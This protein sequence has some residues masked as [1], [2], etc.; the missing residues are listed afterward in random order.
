[1]STKRDNYIENR[2]SEGGSVG[3]KQSLRKAASQEFD[4]IERLTGP[5]PRDCEVCGRP[6]SRTDCQ[7]S[8]MFG[9]DI[10]TPCDW[11]D[12]EGQS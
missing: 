12:E 8:E 10:C 4:E 9:D 5:R 7:L 3:E 6:L 2:V 1:M 11:A